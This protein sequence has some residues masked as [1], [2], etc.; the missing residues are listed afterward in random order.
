MTEIEKSLER[1]EK[2]IS[3]KPKIISI[4]S[5]VLVPIVVAGVAAYVSVYTLQKNLE[6]SDAERDLKRVEVVSA[7]I[8]D[9]SPKYPERTVLLMSV[10]KSAK[11]L[12]SDT[13]DQVEKYALSSTK[14]KFNNALAEGG[15]EASK[16]VEEAVA[17]IQAADTPAAKKLTSEIHE[18][19]FHV[20]A[21]SN[22]TLPNA[23]YF[24]KQLIKS[25]FK[26]AQVI[27]TSKR[28]AVSV[29]YLPYNEAKKIE[30]SFEESSRFHPDYPNAAYLETNKSNWK[31][32]K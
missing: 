17:V 14:G 30:K 13:A 18:T 22:T 21:A 24:K 26:K 27:E 3:K 29:A 23:K 12:D 32:I 5:A 11:I 7:I 4:A 19:K 8:K 9:F 25:G 31:V 15:K 10:V 6:Q 2:E 20:I 1:I 16:T 28:Y